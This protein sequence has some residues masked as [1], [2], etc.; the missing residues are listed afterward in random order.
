V[1]VLEFKPQNC[2]KE[3]EKKSE[4][5]KQEEEVKENVVSGKNRKLKILLYVRL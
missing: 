4:K 2:Q 3:K 1:R 5:E